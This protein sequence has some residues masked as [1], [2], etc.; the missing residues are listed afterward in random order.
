MMNAQNKSPFS[1]VTKKMMLAVVMV[2]GLLVILSGVVIN[3]DKSITVKARVVGVTAR[4]EFASLPEYGYIQAHSVKNALP[5]KIAPATG[6]QALPEYG[7]I[8]AHSRV[9]TQ[10]QTA[11]LPVEL[12]SL[13]EFGYIQAHNRV[14]SLSDNALLNVVFLPEGL[15]SLSEFGYIETHSLKDA[16]TYVAG[17]PIGLRSLPEYS[18]ILAHDP[19]IQR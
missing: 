11:Y 8:Q 3:M 9:S 10:T 14:E 16:Q 17:S 4:Q 15:R 1:K 2:A 18:Y 7:Y 13:V 5:G 19:T 12:R 6:F